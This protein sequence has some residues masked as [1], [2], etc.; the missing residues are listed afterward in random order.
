MF[1]SSSPSPS[2]QHANITCNDLIGR[3]SIDAVSGLGCHKIN[4]PKL[5]A[6]NSLYSE[7]DLSCTDYYTIVYSLTGT[8]NSWETWPGMCTICIE[9]TNS[10]DRRTARQ[11]P[12]N[13]KVSRI[14]LASEDAIAE[15]NEARRRRA[16]H[17][18]PAAHMNAHLPS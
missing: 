9:V 13:K 3:T 10:S 6:R 16:V 12:A 18:L 7:L 11:R 17:R 2:P 5:L 4:Y 15:T 1:N 14:G 8:A